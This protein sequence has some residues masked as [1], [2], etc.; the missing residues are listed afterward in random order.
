VLPTS[1]RLPKRWSEANLVLIGGK[2]FYSFAG[3]VFEPIPVGLVILMEQQRQK[4]LQERRGQVETQAPP[5]CKYCGFETHYNVI[6][7]AFSTVRGL[8]VIEDIPAWLCDR[9]GEQFF[10]DKIPRL[11]KQVMTSP[12]IKP[13]RQICIP[14]FS[15]K[16]L[17]A[18]NWS[19]DTQAS[20]E[21]R[22][23][24]FGS[25]RCWP[26]RAFQPTTVNHDFRD[27]FLCRYCGSQTVEN[28]VKSVFWIDSEPIVVEGIRAKVCQRCGQQFYDDET[29]ER[30]ATLEESRCGAATVSK[31]MLVPIF[32]LTDIKG[33]PA[34]HNHCE[35]DNML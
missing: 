6:K 8:I 17:Q 12:T 2:S 26:S 23:T 20:D 13:K 21:G 22:T 33:S 1:W 5:R 24:S 15:P 32:S 35:K 34:K 30:I 9:C 11:V 31:K 18:A 3:A 16:E 27:T 7:A 4:K 29:A 14:V 10:E 25:T 28:I 19:G